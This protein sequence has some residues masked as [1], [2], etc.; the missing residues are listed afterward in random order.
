LHRLIISL[1]LSLSL[2]VA[3]LV[4]LRNVS[5]GS[6]RGWTKASYTEV[7]NNRSCSYLSIVIKIWF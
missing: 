1:S 7:S 5:Q 6:T 3:D 2:N 4:S